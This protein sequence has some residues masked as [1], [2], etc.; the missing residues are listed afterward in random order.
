M[1]DLDEAVRLLRRSIPLAPADHPERARYLVSLGGARGKWY[2][3]T[4]RPEDAAKAADVLSEA[5]LMGSAAASCRIDA[6]A[7]WCSLAAEREDWPTAVHAAETAVGLLS[8]LAWRG[9]EQAD[10]QHHLRDFTGQARFAASCALQSD[11]P[12]RAVELAEQGR[13]VMWSRLLDTRADLSA[14]RATAPGLAARLDHLR[15]LLD[16]PAQP[17]SLPS[18]RRPRGETAPPDRSALA[19]EWD[20]LVEQV[21]QIDGFTDFLERHGIDR[22]L[23]LGDEGPVVLVNISS[24]RCDA[25]IVTEGRLRVTPLPRVTENEL[26]EQANRCLVRERSDV[27]QLAQP[28]AVT[29]GVLLLLALL[30]GL[31]GALLL[32]RAAHGRPT[33]VPMS[34]VKSRAVADHLEARSAAALRRGIALTLLCVGLLVTAVATTWYGPPHEGP[35]IRVDSPSGS[36]CGSVVRLDAGTMVLDTK[37]GEV[38]VVLDHASALSPVKACPP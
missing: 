22:L 25:L 3:V 6:A 21:R 33:V 10:S 20:D 19:R 4:H 34:A 1:P 2:A 35:A 32:V 13:G 29:V 15:T 37:M 36:V 9:A 24:L 16:A 7:R 26:V 27:G 5:A 18:P 28:W 31:A 30:A 17:S 14:L 8:L 23:A 12:A 11:S 38:K